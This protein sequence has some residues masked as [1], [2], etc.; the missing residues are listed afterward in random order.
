M[1]YMKTCSDN[2]F[3]LAIVDPPYGIGEDWKK[4]SSCV[5]FN[6][7][8]TYKNNSI[9]SSD[10]FI[11]LMRVSKD[12]IIWGGNY[13]TEMLRPSNNWIIWDKKRL[14]NKTFMSEAELAWT[15]F[16]VPMRFYRQQWD[17]AKK[18]QDTGMKKI[19]PHQKPITLY[20]WLL[21]NYASPGQKILDTHL[22]SGSSAIAAHY[23]GFDFVGCELDKD[24]FEAAQARFNDSTRQKAMF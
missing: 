1:E 13:Y 16:K 23:G 11:Q 3:D 24:Y 7:T 18:G 6:H 15:S 22:G 20:N 21:K 2:Q 14:V 10:Y 4:S 17:G 5:H 12:Q 9:P 8:S 19:H